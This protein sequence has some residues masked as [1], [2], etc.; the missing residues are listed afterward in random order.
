[1]STLVKYMVEY[2]TPRRAR[3]ITRKAASS[4][5]RDA[6][7]QGAGVAG[8]EGRDHLEGFG[9]A[10]YR[11]EQPEQRRHGYQHRDDRQ[12][13]LDVAVDTPCAH[14]QGGA[15][16]SGMARLVGL[17]RLPTSSTAIASKK[18]TSRMVCPQKLRVTYVL[19]NITLYNI[20]HYIML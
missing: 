13:P 7:G 20:V 9:H 17:A 4:E 12:I 18:F 3:R 2:M 1:M 16:E 15:I 8:P 10:E 6:A 11:A 19:H 5:N 14:T